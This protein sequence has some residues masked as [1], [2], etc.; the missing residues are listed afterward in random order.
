MTSRRR[1]LT[2][3]AFLATLALAACT[4]T[5]D[6]TTGQS[7][8][9]GAQA[10]EVALPVRAGERILSLG[11]AQPYQPAAPRGGTDDYHCFLVDPHL[12]SPAFI[13]GIGFVPGNASVVH[14]AILF[15][16]PAAQVAAAQATDAKQPGDGWT[17]FGGTDIAGPGGSGGGNEGWLAAWAPGGQPVTYA[18]GLGVPVEAGSRLV[19]QVHYNLL[20]GRQPD[21]TSVRLRLT[22]PAPGIRPLSTVLLP[23]PVELPCTATERG[24]LC[25]RTKAVADVT[26]RFGPEVGMAAA[27]LQQFCG[28]DPRHP[29]AGDTQHCDRR[30]PKPMTVEAAAGHMHLL[31]R[32]IRI[33][34]NPDSPHPQVLLDVPS[35]DFHNQGAVPLAQPVKVRAGDTIRVTCTH[36]AK[37]RG[38]LSELSNLPPRYVVW[39]D[40]T[41]DEMCLGILTV[42]PS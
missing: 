18:E 4:G 2:L 8:Q 15:E 41:S 37:L 14:H 1:S 9:H 26:S 34:L 24:P 39:G 32:A 28:G 12:T 27:G 35:Y 30:V 21:Q 23:A 7:H 22:P 16:V 29:R 11:L 6:R 25:D 3:L 31:G 36:D 40:G 5:G 38:T 10:Q 42:T 17:C 20:A 19:L 33:T 13:N